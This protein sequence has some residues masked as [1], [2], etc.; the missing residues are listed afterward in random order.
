RPSWHEDVTVEVAEDVAQKGALES[1]RFSFRLMGEC[2]IFC[3]VP[4]TRLRIRPESVEHCPLGNIRPDISLEISVGA[5]RGISVGVARC[6]NCQVHFM[7][8]SPIFFC[9]P[10]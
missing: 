7:H 5:V 6:N 1:P 4:S 2:G 8:V 10:P 3:G 9:W